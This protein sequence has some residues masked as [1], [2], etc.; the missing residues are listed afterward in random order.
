MSSKKDQH[1]V[2]IP[3]KPRGQEVGR[4]GTPDKERVAKEEETPALRG[5]RKEA[6][7]M[8]ADKSS[9]HTASDGTK[10]KSNSPSIPAQIGGGRVGESGGETGFKRRQ[11]KIRKTE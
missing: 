10:P 5:R 9:Q 11:K 4:G 7:K 3:A 1:K 6:N 2:G 8:F